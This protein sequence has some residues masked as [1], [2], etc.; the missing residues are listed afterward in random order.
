[1]VGFCFS[2][3][4]GFFCASTVV[5]LLLCACFSFWWTV[6]IFRVCVFLHKLQRED[7]DVL[8]SLSEDI[9]AGPHDIQVLFESSRLPREK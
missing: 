9:L 7:Q 8:S 3:V 4:D 5:L 1:M 6:I 2:T